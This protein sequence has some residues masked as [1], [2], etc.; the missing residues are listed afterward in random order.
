MAYP[1]HTLATLQ[2]PTATQIRA[3]DDHVPGKTGGDS[4]SQWKLGYSSMLA[5]ALGLAPF[6]DNMWSTAEQ[7][8]SSCGANAMEITPSLHNAAST[9]SAGPVSPGDGVG[10]SDV[11]Q[12]MRSCT[13]SGRL[14]HP[15]R[16]MTA[17]DSQVLGDV[18]GAGAGRPT[19]DVYATYSVVSTWAWDH[20][21][22]VNLQSPYSV[23][24][25]DL[26]GIRGDLSLRSASAAPPPGGISYSVN[27]STMEFTTL[28]VLPFSATQPIPLAAC[29]FQD[30]QVVHTAPVFT[31]GW[32]LLGELSKWVPVAEARLSDISMSSSDVTMVVTGQAGE[33]V[34]ITFYNTLTSTTVTVVCVLP[35]GGVATLSVAANA[36]G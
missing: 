27:A 12:I 13:A 18:F 35:E 19:G 1:R 21:M 7:P 8:G 29:G 34:P 6:K 28:K 36:C 4:T 17:L 16:P 15:S 30:F 33:S 23:T 2:M 14:L 3:S 5:W 25:G 20:V 11:P 10:M 24:Q 32:A 31:N 22:G 26:E 9:F